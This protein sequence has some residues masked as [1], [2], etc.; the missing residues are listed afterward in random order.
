MTHKTKGTLVKMILLTVLLG[1]VTAVFFILHRVYQKVWMNATAISCL[2]TFYH[3]T[4]RIAV[5]ETVTLIFAKREFPKDRL[6][7]HL[8]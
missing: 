6:G 2:T 8:F 3:L 4:M 1:G 5:G 7:F